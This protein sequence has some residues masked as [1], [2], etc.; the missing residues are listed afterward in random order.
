MGLDEERRRGCVNNEEVV[1]PRCRD[2]GCGSV[3]C[4]SLCLPLVYCTA[5]VYWTIGDTAVAAPPSSKGQ[6]GNL[7]RHLIA[8]CVTRFQDSFLIKECC[9]TPC[10]AG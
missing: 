1:T 5:L 9:R 7:L 3:C 6:D 8:T 2:R 10:T 4:H